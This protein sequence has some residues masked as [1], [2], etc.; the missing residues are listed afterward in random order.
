MEQHVGVR[1]TQ[2]P[3]R[4]AYAIFMPTLCQGDVP[5]WYDGDTGPPTVYESELAAQREIA[6]HHL[7]LIREFLDAER[8]YQDAIEV[9]D[10]LLPVDVWPDGSIS[11]EDGRSFSKR[12]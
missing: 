7:T 12:E 6:D 8:G 5:C 10:Y 4:S 3:I 9:T 11:T 1:K 2:Q